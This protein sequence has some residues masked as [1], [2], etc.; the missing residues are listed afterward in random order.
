MREMEDFLVV[1]GY[2]MIGAWPEL[3]R[4]KDVNLEEARD[5]LIE[6]LSDYQAFSGMKTYV[7]FDAYKVP[8][9]GGKYRQSRIQIW[10]TK[11]KETADEVIER[12]VGSLSGRRRRVIVATSDLAEQYI[13]FGQGALRKSAREL[14]FDIRESRREV[15]KHLDEMDTKATNSF[16]SKLSGELRQKFEKWRRGQ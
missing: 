15:R 16:D 9:L 4:L 2:N 7:V 5:R 1:D 6:M 11:E 13:A 14:Y 12:L 3:Q 10:Y 8:G